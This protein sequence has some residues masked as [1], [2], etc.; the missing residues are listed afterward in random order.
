MY[1]NGMIL[2]DYIIVASY[3]LDLNNHWDFDYVT[4]MD[5][6]TGVML[7]ICLLYTSPSP[8]D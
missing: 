7:L 4:S 6:Q 5:Y 8:R 3:S 2:E 1:S